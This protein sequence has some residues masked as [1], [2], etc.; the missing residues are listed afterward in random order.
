MSSKTKRRII[1][2]LTL[3]TVKA[4]EGIKV[5]RRER[6]REKESGQ[7]GECWIWHVFIHELSTTHVG[8]LKSTLMI[9]VFGA[10]TPSSPLK[11]E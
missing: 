10:D 8:G 7:R 6:E 4:S 3:A 1:K 5:K 9:F 11:S 2:I